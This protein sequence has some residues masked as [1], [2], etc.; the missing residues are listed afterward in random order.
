VVGGIGDPQDIPWFW[1]KFAFSCE[2]KTFSV[3]KPR[4][5]TIW[6]GGFCFSGSKNGQQLFLIDTKAVL[7]ANQRFEGK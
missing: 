6:S 5:L 2:H 4:W 7:T 3:A 1:C